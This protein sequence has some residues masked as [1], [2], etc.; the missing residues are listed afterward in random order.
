[1]LEGPFEEISVILKV[2]ESVSEL[3]EMVLEVLKR[4]SVRVP[5]AIFEA[6]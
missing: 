5:E 1:M 3:E 4:V 2:F 6:S